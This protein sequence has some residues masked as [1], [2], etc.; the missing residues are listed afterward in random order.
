MD[1]QTPTNAQSQGSKPE[2]SDSS[3]PV[4]YESIV[5]QVVEKIKNEP[6]LFVIAIAALLIGFA[7]VASGLGSSDLR[8]IVIVIAALAFVVII[9]YYVQAGMQMRTPMQ[10][11]ERAREEHSQTAGEGAVTPAEETQPAIPPGTSET[12]VEAP[13]SIIGAI[14]PGGRVE[15]QIN[16]PG[17]SR[18]G[19]AGAAAGLTVDEQRTAL[20]DELAQHQ[21]NLARLRAK[22]AIY[23][24]GEE[25][26]SLLNQIEHEER[27]IE[28]VQAEWANL[29]ATD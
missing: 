8:F 11:A 19:E 9:G 26:L 3:R 16:R 7:V 27:E 10:P 1:E 4:P 14:G 17:S 2:E 23:A 12:I 25:P 21:R 24:A 28:R 6:F 22:K 29:G 15:Q 18:D 20:E 13:N 5:S